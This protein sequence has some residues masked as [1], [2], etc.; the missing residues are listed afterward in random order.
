MKKNKNYFRFSELKLEVLEDKCFLHRIVANK[1]GIVYC[2]YQKG[3][4][5]NNI[6]HVS[7][8]FM[9]IIRGQ[10]EAKIGKAKH[11]L[12]KGDGVLIP[13]KRLHSFVA[14]KKTIA[15]VVFA[16]PITSKQAKAIMKK[17]A[18]RKSGIKR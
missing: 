14:M 15:L 6:R 17:S 12:K 4:V 2:E 1:M 9:Y 13:S 8:E 3:W 7:E 11:I 10:L 18:G 5:H 16:P